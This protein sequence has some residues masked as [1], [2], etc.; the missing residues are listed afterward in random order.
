MLRDP[1]DTLTA[2]LDAGPH[3]G[4]H[5]HLDK[6]GLYLYGDGVAWQPAPGVPPYGSPLRRDYYARTLAHPTVRVDEKDQL[7]TTG[8]IKLVE[9]DG[10]GH[11]AWRPRDG[12]IEGVD[13]TR[14]VVMTPTYLLDV[15]RVRCWHRSGSASAT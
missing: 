9:L 4:S 12:A 8:T 2:I 3:G 6:L 10:V 7:P 5:G 1:A 14:E 15:V 13:L 11:A